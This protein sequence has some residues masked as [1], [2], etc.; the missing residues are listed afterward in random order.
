MP[1]L[2][3]TIDYNIYKSNLRKLNKREKIKLY[4]PDAGAKQ[5]C[6][7]NFTHNLKTPIRKHMHTKQLYNPG[8]GTLEKSQHK[9]L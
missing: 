2:E 4:Q 9:T 1:S 8:V 5:F 7:N 3:V 6:M